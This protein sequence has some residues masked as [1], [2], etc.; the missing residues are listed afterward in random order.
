MLLV[1][2]RLQLYRPRPAAAKWG[3][4]G[5]PC[6]A[7]WA[8]GTACA[9]SCSWKGLW[10]GR[11]GLPLKRS[12]RHAPALFANHRSASQ[13]H[14]LAG[15]MTCQ[16][17]NRVCSMLTVHNSQPFVSLRVKSFFT[18]LH[19]ANICIGKQ[20]LLHCHSHVSCIN[21]LDHQSSPTCNTMYW[22]AVPR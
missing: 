16:K 5:G 13:I 15:C 20:I 9:S 21:L 17:Y 11:T 6:G 4:L 19:K 2:W 7:A 8:C 10:R 3:G 22:V 14:I 1:L 18:C 12:C